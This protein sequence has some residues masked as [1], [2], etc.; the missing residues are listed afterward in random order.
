MLSADELKRYARQLVLPEVGMAGQQRLQE[1]RVLVV[2]A[3]GLGSP[4]A[5]Y[6]A[7]AGVG[8]IGIVDNDVVE[9]S[10]LH[11]QILHSTD[12]V[13]R[14]K[15][16]SAIDALQRLNPHVNVRGHAVRLDDATARTIIPEYDLIVDGSDNYA[17]RYAVNDRCAQAEV[18][19]IYGS[20]ERFSG[21]VAVFA[22]G[23][24]P[25]Y[26]CVFPEPPAPGA[27]PSC[28]DIGV[29]GAVPGVIGTLQAVEAL[30]LLLDTDRDQT[31][32][33][34]QI[35]FGRMA[36]R[37]IQIPARADCPAC[38]G[39]AHPNARTESRTN[40]DGSE[41]HPRELAALLKSG[42]VP[43]VLDVREPWEREVARIDASRLIPMDQLPDALESLPTD[44]DIVVYCHHGTRSALAVQWLR[45]HGYRARNLTGG[46][47]TW[48]ATVDP[49]IP[50]Y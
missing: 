28:E 41:M 23:G 39:I 22:A 33:L 14:Q 47:D 3:G 30:K 25:C 20:V 2:G 29:L 11:R 45:R 16:A 6:L 17:T 42:R 32:R 46:I 38:A 26:R 24:K 5:L 27:S 15:S 37:S 4:V 21:Q 31:G 9:I 7:A 13:G 8:T 40:G 35:D 10:N 44:G 48:S 49:S 43:L 36:W 34:L 50:R 12:D 1:A 19:W 18:P